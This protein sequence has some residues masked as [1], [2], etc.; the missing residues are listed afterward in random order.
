MITAIA[1]LGHSPVSWLIQH[2]TQQPASHFALC[3]DDRLVFHSDLL[4][5]HPVFRASF[6]KTHD[7]VK[8]V[9]IDANKETEDQVWNACYSFDGREYDYPAFAYFLAYGLTHLWAKQRLPT[10]NPWAENGSFL[11]TEVAKALRPCF[12]NVPAP[13]WYKLSAKTP[14]DLITDIQSWQADPNGETQKK[15]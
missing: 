2:G 13:Y 10:Q 8:E 14:W 12:P 6:L 11:C 1:A 5:T 3:F 9:Q 4:G 7:I 15:D